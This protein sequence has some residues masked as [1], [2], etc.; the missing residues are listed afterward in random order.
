MQHPP[1]L[2]KWNERVRS[3][4]KKK[5]KEIREFSEKG[6]GVSGNWQIMGKVMVSPLYVWFPLSDIDP[7]FKSWTSPIQLRT[8]WPPIKLL[9]FASL[10]WYSHL[11][12][13]NS[14]IPF[15]SF[16]WPH[17]LPLLQTPKLSLIATLKLNW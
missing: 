3:Q 5:R 9:F 12:P 4:K 17:R 14:G 13:R 2:S 15:E 8:I 16:Q 6:E 1:N 7:L 10:A 11:F